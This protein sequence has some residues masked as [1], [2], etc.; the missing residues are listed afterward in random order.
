[1]QRAKVPGIICAEDD[2]RYD[3]AEVI[4]HEQ[5]DRDEAD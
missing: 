3:R 5:D 2:D 1:M 4:E